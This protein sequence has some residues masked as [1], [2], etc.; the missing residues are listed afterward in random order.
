MVSTLVEEM[1]N[2]ANVAL[3]LCPMLTRDAI[4][5][6][7]SEELKRTYL[8][9]MLSVEWTVTM[10]LTGL[11]ADSDLSAVRTKAIPPGDGT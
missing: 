7:G 2:G 4:E 8:P 11:Q 10:S 3:T 5:L 6:R 9:K 1:R